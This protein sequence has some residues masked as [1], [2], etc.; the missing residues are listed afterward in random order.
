MAALSKPPHSR[1]DAAQERDNTIVALPAF[2]I[3]AIAGL[4]AW[5]QP[6]SINWAANPAS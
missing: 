2:L 3:G 6:V 4:R 1:S 5:T